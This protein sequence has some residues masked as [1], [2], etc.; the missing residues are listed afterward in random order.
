MP[1]FLARLPR[2]VRLLPGVLTLAAALAAC[3]PTLDTVPAPTAGT[4]N[5]SRYIAVGNSLTAG[6]ADNGLYLEG[7]LTSYPSQLARQ[8]AL[9]GGGAFVQ[10][11]FPEN[12]PNGNGYLRLTGFDAAGAPVL[13]RVTTGLAV[14]GTSPRG[15]VLTK[16][17]GD[18]N[19][20]GVPGLRMAEI[21][22]TSL[23][24][25]NSTSGPYNPLFERLQ[26]D[27]VTNQTYLQ[28]V[29]LARPT[30]FTCWLGN[31]DVLGYATSGGA[32]SGSP[33]YEMTALASFT[34]RAH[35]LLDTLTVDGAQ[36]VVALIPNVTAIPFFTTVG[37]QVKA[38]LAA[39]NEPQLVVTTGAFEILGSGATRRTIDATDIQ[40][41]AGGRQLFTLTGGAY[42]PLIG[43]PSGLY[44]RTFYADVVPGLGFPV[45]WADFERAL[46][47]DTTQRFGLSDRNPWPSTL[48]LDDVEQ[49]AVQA[50]TAAFNDVLRAK[51]VSKNLPVF[52][53]Y[54]FFNEVAARG[55][56]TNGVVNTTAY[57]S[58]N[59]FS[60]DGV[61][62]TA[63]G[64][65][66]ITNELLRIINQRYNATLPF[67]DPAMYRG[68]RLP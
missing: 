62:P 7:Q 46:N 6:F 53:A 55:A 64:Y 56:V 5:F 2:P 54:T 10:P 4:A 29:A 1:F 21:D 61:H 35:K 14:R 38:R 19:N 24:N 28:R 40:T 42:V 58:G 3:E 65:A 22:A 16:F 25:A 30:F 48:L 50:R 23:G 17:T 44:W 20:L 32:I 49:A 67:V 63:R 36:G 60:L 41:A 59:L 33:S 8:F 15:E 11:L 66:L 18:I 52:D 27:G 9:A 12:Q 43:T 45:P 31:N 13:T 47:L 39:L 26:P 51:A 68:V 57:V 34:T 37:P